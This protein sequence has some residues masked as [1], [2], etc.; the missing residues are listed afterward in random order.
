MNVEAWEVID[1]NAQYIILQSIYCSCEKTK[2][3]FL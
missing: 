3:Y 1:N 2:A